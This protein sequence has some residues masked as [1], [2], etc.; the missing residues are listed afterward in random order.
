M[1]DKGGSS[2]Y[3]AGKC[4][5]QSSPRGASKVTWPRGPWKWRAVE[6]KENQQQVS[7]SSHR[8]W[9]SPKARFPH[10]HRPDGDAFASPFQ[11]KQEHRTIRGPRPIRDSI[12]LSTSNR[13]APS[14]RTSRHYPHQT[15]RRL[16]SSSVL[17]V[18]LTME[19]LLLFQLRQY[20][21]GCVSNYSLPS[22][23]CR[24]ASHGADNRRRNCQ[25]R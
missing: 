6:S 5:S 18:I 22:F 13:R 25:R 8:P 24:A 19:R 23:L 10:S 4:T 20:T 3:D 15:A 2:L 17:S 11:P 9:K 21:I 16:S 1:G 14:L 12:Q 7:P